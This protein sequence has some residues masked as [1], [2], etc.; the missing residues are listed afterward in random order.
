MQISRRDTLMGA[1]AAVAV[2][3]VP[4]AV[5]AQPDPLLAGVQALVNEIR[6]DLGPGVMMAVYWAL[7]EKADRLEALPGIQALANELW[8]PENRD[9]ARRCGMVQVLRPVG[10][11]PS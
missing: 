9:N 10:G 6:Q 1:T 4:M 5:G 2:A 8:T 11:L 7:Q 3:G